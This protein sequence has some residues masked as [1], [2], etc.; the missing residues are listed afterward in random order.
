MSAAAARRRKQLAASRGKDNVVL[1]Q[2]SSLLEQPELTEEVA[3]EALQ[4]AVSS[5]R[6]HVKDQKFEEA[7]DLAYDVSLKLLRFHR[8]SVASQIM[9]E[10]ADVLRE[11]HTECKEEPW[12]KRV[13]ELHTEFQT[14]VQASSTLP[15]P[16]VTRLERLERSW[17]LLMVQWSADLGDIKFGHNAIQELL[18]EQCWKLS[19]LVAESDDEETSE[20]QCDA[21]Q[22]LVLAEKP[23]QIADILR[24]LPPPTPEQIKAGHTCPP[25]IR[26]ALLTRAIL[27]FCAVEN[28]RDAN[29]LLR[30]YIDHIEERDVK[31]LAESYTNKSDG[32][33]P[34]H[35][36]F[37]CMLLRICE[38]NVRTGPL[39]QWLLK[40]FKRELENTAK[41]AALATFTTKI[42]KIYFNIQPPP[43]MLSM[44]ENMMMGGPGGMGGG[45]NPAMM[46]A[47]M[48][49]LQNM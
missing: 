27:L 19:K 47:A 18:G 39:Y 10:L 21:I 8:V 46:Q 49:Q 48:A 33:A 26:D 11:T 22:H 3:Y 36:I 4:L 43:S 15:A 13:V 40:S 14:A 7:C 37:A 34:S 5:V 25:A 23:N 2:L 1:S 30:E 24:Q 45:I 32:L 28:L 38:K 16:E 12:I 44:M 41:P 42:G 20:L 31:T 9:Q 17:L 35:V 29:V 6:R